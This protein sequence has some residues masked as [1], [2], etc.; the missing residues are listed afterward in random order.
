MA[1]MLSK[2]E[3]PGFDTL[4]HNWEL[5]ISRPTTGVQADGSEPEWKP[6]WKHCPVTVHFK[7]KHI[8]VENT[9]V[10]YRAIVSESELPRAH[11][12]MDQAYKKI[13]MD[14][15][16]LDVMGV[17]GPMLGESLRVDSLEGCER[18]KDK[19]KLRKKAASDEIALITAEKDHALILW[20]YDGLGTLARLPSKVRV[21]IYELAFPRLFKQRFWQ[22]YY[23]KKPG[24]TLLGAT[25]SSPVPDIC[26]L[27]TA[28]RNDVLDSV[29]R[30]Q[31]SRIIIDGQI[32][33][34]NFPLNPALQRGGSVDAAHAKIHASKELFIGIQVPD[35]RDVRDVAAVRSNVE[36]VVELL[37]SIAA[38]H[39]LTPIRVSFNT[40]AETRDRPDQYYRCDYEIYLGPLRNLR[41]PLNSPELGPGQLLAIERLGPEQG[42]HEEVEATCKKIERAVCQPSEDA[43]LLTYRQNVIDVKVELATYQKRKRDP[44]WAPRH[45]YKPST[46]RIAAAAKALDAFYTAK[47]LPPP[48]WVTVALAQL[49]D[50][51]VVVNK[52]E[53]NQRLDQI[54]RSL[55]T[56]GA[57]TCS[58]SQDLG[59]RRRLTLTC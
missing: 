51:G 7:S 30:G 34:F 35:P 44:E 54:L 16:V 31:A 12:D 24:L 28:L 43:S 25:H 36:R 6:G 17:D 9:L 20:G 37:N 29:Y 1:I 18:K 48:S 57:P 27:S 26:R 55:E 56:P 13:L 22:C 58:G 10:C 47:N 4:S 59:L 11:S 45:P 46:Q 3:W 41:L 53:R 32:V 49:P 19:S 40:N 5:S 50:G 23:T 42:L 15:S 33:A 21:R 2:Q 14:W 52:E 8:R 39:P 38:N